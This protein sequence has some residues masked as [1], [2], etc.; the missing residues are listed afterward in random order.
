MYVHILYTRDIAVANWLWSG[1]V[2]S[3]PVSILPLD[4]FQHQQL[5][6]FFCW[7]FRKHSLRVYKNTVSDFRHFGL[8]G[9]MRVYCRFQD[10]ISRRNKIRSIVGGFFFFTP[11]KSVPLLGT[12]IYFFEYKT[13]NM[14]TRTL[15]VYSKNTAARSIYIS[16]VHSNFEDNGAEPKSSDIAF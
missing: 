8:S 7:F 1:A 13:Y 6:I 4:G 11:W 2:V 9:H 15:Y 5:W 12:Q 3:E 14:S 10:Y 16:F